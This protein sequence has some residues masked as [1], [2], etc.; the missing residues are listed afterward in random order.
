MGAFRRRMNS[1]LSAYFPEKR[2]F[3]QS[4][5]ST[6]YLRLS[7]LSQFMSG[8]AS[9]AMV[10]WMAVAT[11]TIAIDLVAGRGRTTLW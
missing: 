6:R 3:I 1:A 5:N 2:L 9:L 7:P 4:G 10:G 8:A 11:A